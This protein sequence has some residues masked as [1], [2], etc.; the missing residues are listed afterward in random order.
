MVAAAGSVTTR[1]TMMRASPAETWST[2][3]SRMPTKK[4]AAAKKPA[5]KKPAAKKPT[6]KMAK[7]EHPR[8][9]L[10]TD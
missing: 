2:R 9:T 3:R 5:A 7:G 4:K 1:Q 10:A 6:K 8:G